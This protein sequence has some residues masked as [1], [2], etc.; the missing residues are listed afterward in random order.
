MLPGPT[1]AKWDRVPYFV[2]CG[3][4]SG[5]V[6]EAVLALQAGASFT[7]VDI[8]QGM[9]SEGFVCSVETDPA[10]CNSTG[11]ESRM[12]EA[13]ARIRAV[14]PEAK[15]VFYYTCDNVRMESDLGR[16]F[17]EEHPEL[18]LRRYAVDRRSGRL[19]PFQMYQYDWSNPA[20]V[21]AWAKGIATAVKKGKFDGVFIDGTISYSDVATLPV[22]HC[23]LRTLLSKAIA[24]DKH[25]DMRVGM[26][27]DPV[28]KQKTSVSAR[29]DI[30]LAVLACLAASAPLL[31]IALSTLLPTC[32]IYGTRQGPHWLSC[33]IQGQ[34][35]FRTVSMA[36]VVAMAM[37]L[38]AYQ[39]TRALWK[40]SLERLASYRIRLMQLME[41]SQAMT[42]ALPAS[43]SW[44]EGE[45]F[46]KS[47]GQTKKIKI[48]RCLHW[49]HFCLEQEKTNIL[50]SLGGIGIV[51]KSP[52]VRLSNYTDGLWANP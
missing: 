16:W 20:T 42:K 2:Q 48:M 38:P 29:L 4:A 47:T 31:A 5:P 49:Q 41:S 37:A 52:L 17:V 51:Q 50:A 40:N 33:W 15:A 18:L 39:A 25:Q 12:A 44:L 30:S 22:K 43:P 28:Q 8:Q 10:A 36:M 6:S 27:A 11:A 13:A 34:F 24:L 21:Q 7:V 3:N 46:R 45:P 1:A 35:L 19:G 23:C 14:N 32:K 9:E 26:G